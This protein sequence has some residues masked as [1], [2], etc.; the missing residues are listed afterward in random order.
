MIVLYKLDIVNQIYFKII[1]F[2]YNRNFMSNLWKIITKKLTIF[3]LYFIIYYIE[4][5]SASK[6]RYPTISFFKIIYTYNA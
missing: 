3:L 6:R 2:D 5:N 4:I 1:F